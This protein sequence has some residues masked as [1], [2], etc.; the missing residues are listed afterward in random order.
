MVENTRRIYMYTR[1]RNLYNNSYFFPFTSYLANCEV[2]N[3]MGAIQA[4]IQK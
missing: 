4:C 1:E 2:I 3:H